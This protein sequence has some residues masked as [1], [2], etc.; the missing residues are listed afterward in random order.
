M[1]PGYDLDGLD[2]V[3]ILEVD[4][5]V[6][7]R[8]D[9]CRHDTWVGKDE[10]AQLVRLT[11]PEGVPPGATLPA[12]HVAKARSSREGFAGFFAPG[13]NDGL[14]LTKRPYTCDC[15]WKARF[16][17]P[18]ED[19]SGLMN[20]MFGKPAADDGSA[21]FA[22]CCGGEDHAQEAANR[23]LR[24]R[25]PR[26]GDADVSEI[27]AMSS[28]AAGAAASPTIVKAAFKSVFK[29]VLAVFSMLDKRASD[30][31]TEEEFR[32]WAA[33]KSDDA[34]LEKHIGEFV[35]ECMPLG[36][37][38][39]AVD[40]T[41]NR[42]EANRSR[43]AS[44]PL[45]PSEERAW[46][47]SYRGIDG[48]YVDNTALAMTVATMITDCLAG[49]ETLDC[50]D[51]TLDVVLVNDGNS[52]PAANGLGSFFSDTGT[53]VGTYHHTGGPKG[54]ALVPS[55]MIF[56]EP[57]PKNFTN[58]FTPS[59]IAAVKGD[60]RRHRQKMERRERDMDFSDNFSFAPPEEEEGLSLS[61]G[62]SVFA[63]LEDA[64]DNSDVVA[65]GWQGDP[66]AQ[67]PPATKRKRGFFPWEKAEPVPPYNGS[68][69]VSGTFT[70]ID[71]PQWGVNLL[72]F[73][74]AYP[75]DP[76]LQSG[77][78]FSNDPIIL[79]ALTAATFFDTLYEPI[80]RRCGVVSARGE[81]ERATPHLTR[82]LHERSVERAT[83]KR[84]ERERTKEESAA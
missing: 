76:L 6:A 1:R 73:C 33:G 61:D 52:D 41:L 35:D 65:A 13:L 84:A 36:L 12:V 56:A 75:Q 80:A 51:K 62:Q 30:A 68:S 25:W 18:G 53:P 17:C 81:V 50:A 27:T 31:P 5:I 83:N 3:S 16:S 57:Y 26:P 42:T 70:T 74:L 69:L 37:H 10:D 64:S 79:P 22:Y 67:P 34:F 47:P 59:A 14:T 54:L 43:I 38:H 2:S 55:Q 32:W 11:L 23:T 82:W 19:R 29:D 58:Y 78:G 60:I 7:W 21:C 39:L 46:S 71:N 28:A 8:H 63:A 15:S 40:V 72:V 44:S 77:V 20:R 66:D 45:P 48:V 4:D 24:T 9:R 49:D